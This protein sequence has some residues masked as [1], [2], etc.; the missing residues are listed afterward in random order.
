MPICFLILDA[1]EIH[2][3]EDQ[4]CCFNI[5]Q[6]IQSPTPPVARRMIEGIFPLCAEKPANLTSRV[7]Y[8]LLQNPSQDSPLQASSCILSYT[9]LGQYPLSGLGRLYVAS[10]M[11]I[12]P[13]CL[14]NFHIHGSLLLRDRKNPI[15]RLPFNNLLSFICN[16]SPA[17]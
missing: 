1:W 7:P 11:C 17:T 12:E 14:L 6:I 8:L 9:Y 15:D 10:S 2:K 4:S 16:S 3:L 5:F 13:E